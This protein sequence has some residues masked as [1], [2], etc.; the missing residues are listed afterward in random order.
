MTNIKLSGDSRSLLTIQRRD[1]GVSAG[2][3]PPMLVL[4]GAIVVVFIGLACLFK[5][6]FWK[7]AF[8]GRTRQREWVGARSRRD[9]WT[10]PV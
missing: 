9:N 6:W 4:I 8:P 1:D 2:V 10:V 3:S 5:V 7:R